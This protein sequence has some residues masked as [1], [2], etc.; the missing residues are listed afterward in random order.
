MLLK[1]QWLMMFNANAI[2]QHTIGLYFRLTELSV[3]PKISGARKERQS[4]KTINTNM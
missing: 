4:S 3:C 2:V 1:F